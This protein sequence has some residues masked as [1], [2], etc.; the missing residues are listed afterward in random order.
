LPFAK[1]AKSGPF[2]HIADCPV[3]NPNFTLIG[4]PSF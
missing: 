1:I 2:R 3:F 4:P